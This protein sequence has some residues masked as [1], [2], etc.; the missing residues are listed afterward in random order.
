MN[1]V[2]PISSLASTVNNLLMDN[3]DREK[4]GD[5]L[6]SETIDDIRSAIQT[7]EKRSQGLLHFV[8]SYRKLTR[9]P[10]PDFQICSV[11]SIFNRVNQLMNKQISDLN[12]LINVNVEPE[13]L[14]ITADPELIEQVLINL[15]LNA[16]DAVK[17]K[18]QPRID[19]ISKIDDRGRVIIQVIDNGIGIMQEVQ[20]KIFIPFFTTKKHGSGI[21]LSL[22]RQIMRLHRGTISVRSTPGDST[23]FTLRF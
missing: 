3:I 21:G 23:I 2:T 10:R 20:E 16:I 9:L 18:Q 5:Q 14:E 1:S 13:T 6:Y 22:S 7:I 19:L 15:L 11:A 4:A 17:E 8:E 12:I